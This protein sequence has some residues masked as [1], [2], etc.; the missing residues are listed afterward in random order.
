MSDRNGTAGVPVNAPL[1]LSILKRSAEH[2]QRITPR[3][4]RA[5]STRTF[6]LIRLD[7]ETVS[8]LT[9]TDEGKRINS[10]LH[11]DE[12]RRVRLEK[13]AK[14]KRENP[15]TVVS[16]AMA[17]LRALPSFLGNVL[18]RDLARL[19]RKQQSAR[20]EGVKNNNTHVADNFV[21]RGL[22]TRLKRIE[23]VNECFR[24]DGIQSHRSTP[25]P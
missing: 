16:E 22:R 23:Q 3:P 14:H 11:H 2:N 25:S 5:T 18:I 10:H 8:F 1:P 20:N 19:N 15:P 9:N 21:R 6:A 4:F 24:H 12:E 13:L 17:E 7:E